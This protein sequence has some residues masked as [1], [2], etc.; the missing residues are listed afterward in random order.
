[1]YTIEQIKQD[2][3]KYLSEYRY[4]HSILV[5]EEARKIA[6]HYNQNEE[7]AYIAGLVHDIAKEF[8][9]E[10][11]EKWIKKYNLTG[12]IYSEEYKNVIHSFIGAVAIKEWYEMEEEICNAVRNHTLGNISMTELDKIIFVADKIARRVSNPIIEEERKLAYLDINKALELCFKVQK[13]K[14][15]E[16]GKKMHPIS[17]ELLRLLETNK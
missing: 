3:K 1:M 7:K 11:N 4:E 15:K 8:S 13:Q 6:K 14:L 2:L 12:D 10:E 9:D 16:K 5:A 17:L